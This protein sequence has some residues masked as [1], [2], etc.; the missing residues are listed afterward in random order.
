MTGTNSIPPTPPGMPVLGH[1]TAFASDPFGFVKQSVESVGD[2]FRMQLLG[3]DVYFL[4][5]PDH[6]ETAL[7]DRETFTKPDDFT[8]AFGEALLS[9]DGE[10][11]RRQRHAM[12]DF[13]SPT[14]IQ[15]YAETMTGVTSARIDSWE[16]S[17]TIRID[18]EMRAIALHN[19]FEV[20][21]GQSLTDDA[22]D[23]LA[24]AAHA[25]NL[26]FKPTSWVLPDWVPTPARYK[27]QRGAGELREHARSLLAEHGDDPTDDSLLATL[28]ALRAD[29]DSAFDRNEVLDQVVGMVFAGHETTAL[30]MTYALHQIASHPA[31][32]ERFYAELD[33]V[34]DGQPTVSDLQDLEYLEQII[35]ETLRLYPPVHAIPRVTTNRV[36]IG[37]HTI[38]D[39]AQVLL[40]V[41]NMHRDPR[42]YET[43]L[44]FDPNRWEQVTPRAHGAAFVPFGAGPRICIGRHFA[45]L[46]MKAVLAAIGKQYQLDASGDLEV[47]P[48][49]T[50]QPAG[51]VSIQIEPRA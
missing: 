12:E 26:W 50:S 4:A 44:T 31:V 29:P 37:G 21:L 19:L 34:I 28:A 30:A 49:M 40:S 9:V 51:P 10:Q 24:A 41:W 36:E 46:E 38:P 6:V 48:Q 33:D 20:V 25:L 11:W 1:T 42:F 5:H 27:F 2:V 16:A 17:D 18:D 35:N 47:D 15:E 13:F 22:V 23:E 32:A 45:R 14:R 7:L 39:D 3:T 43:P 8:V